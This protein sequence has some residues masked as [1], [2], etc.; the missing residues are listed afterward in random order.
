MVY[1]FMNT[2][3]NSILL[4]TQ[5]KLHNQFFMRCTIYI[6]GIYSSFILV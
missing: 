5:N 1:V 2:D 3:D 6:R 4:K